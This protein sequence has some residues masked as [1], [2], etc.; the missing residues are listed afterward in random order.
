MEIDFKENIVIVSEDVNEIAIDKLMLGETSYVPVV[1]QNIIP[2]LVVGSYKLEDLYTTSDDLYVF[3]SKMNMLNTYTIDRINSWYTERINIIL[4]HMLDITIDSFDKDYSDLMSYVHNNLDSKTKV[5]VCEAI[6]RLYKDNREVYL[7]LS[8]SELKHP[9]DVV[10]VIEHTII[11]SD[12]FDM[13]TIS[14]PHVV[15][16]PMLYTIQCALTGKCII[17][18]V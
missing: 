11:Y 7:S 15:N 1:K 12:K 3:N 4:K 17:K 16:H 8:P 10:Y 5:S 9:H 13:N 14:Y 6:D 2:H 18:V